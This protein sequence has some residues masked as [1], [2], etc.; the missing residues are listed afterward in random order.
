MGQTEVEIANRALIRL[1]LQT[2]S[3]SYTTFSAAIAGGDTKNSTAIL[4]ANFQ[5]WKKELLRIHP[6]NFA[7]SR[8][9]LIN[10]IAQNPASLVIKQYLRALTSPNNDSPTLT[11]DLTPE[12]GASNFDHHLYDFDV[13]EVKDSKDSRLNGNKY[14]VKRG[15][16]DSSDPVDFDVAWSDPNTVISLYTRIGADGN[17]AGP[18]DTTGW[19]YIN[20]SN[21]D[22]VYNTGTVESTEKSEFQYEYN[23]P[24]KVIRLLEVREIENE[25]EWVIQRRDTS[26]DS[27]DSMVIL[28]NVEDS[29]SIEFINDIRIGSNEV[30]RLFAE[31]LSLKC[32]LNLSETLLKTTSSTREIEAEYMRAVTQAKSIDAQEN[33]PKYKEDSSWFEEMRRST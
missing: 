2:I 26:E 1:G 24:S 15:Y 18:I 5:E 30:D 11:I 3:S 14:Y 17:L 29:I 8:L 19:P 23:L 27:E 7:T 21:V 22:N 13:I 10:P 28:C 25:D 9:T 31:A 20:W 4:N 16:W 12:S 33:S 6:W 32:A